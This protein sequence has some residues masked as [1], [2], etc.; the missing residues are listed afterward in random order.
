MANSDQAPPAHGDE[1][2]L[3]RRFNPRLM[4]Y[5]SGVVKITASD[6]LEEACAHAWAQFMQHQPDRGDTGRAW[7]S[8][9]A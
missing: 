4:R 5:V 6:T 1:A 2:E 7:L 9:A 3:F 8:V